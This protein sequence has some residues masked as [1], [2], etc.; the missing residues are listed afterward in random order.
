MELIFISWLVTF[1]VWEQT[2]C[3]IVKMTAA[4]LCQSMVAL[5]DYCHIASIKLEL[6]SLYIYSHMSHV[7]THTHV[8]LTFYRSADKDVRVFASVL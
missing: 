3:A 1:I 8:H 5:R 2:V 4:E 7:Y 6:S